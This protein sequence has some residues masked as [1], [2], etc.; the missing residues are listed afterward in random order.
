MTSENGRPA[1]GSFRFNY[2]IEPPNSFMTFVMLQVMGEV[3]DDRDLWEWLNA[4]TKGWTNVNLDVH[5]NGARIPAPQFFAK[6]EQAFRAGVEKEA[7]RMLE[8]AGLEDL[9]MYLLHVQDVVKERIRVQMAA[10][11]VELPESKS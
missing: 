6:L 7:A 9:S 1:P 3:I 5:V 10:I 11:G 4:E 8:A 2:Q